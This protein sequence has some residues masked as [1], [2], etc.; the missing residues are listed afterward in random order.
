MRALQGG[1][2][3]TQQQGFYWLV[4]FHKGHKSFECVRACACTAAGSEA[5]IIS[6]RKCST[7][8]TKTLCTLERM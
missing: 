4:N 5:R 8:K 3:V 1:G 7:K 6:S 2:A